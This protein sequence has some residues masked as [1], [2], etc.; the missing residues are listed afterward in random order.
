MGQPSARGGAG[1]PSAGGGWVSC[2]LEVG[3]GVNCQLE[4]DWSAVS[5]MWAGQPSAIYELDSASTLT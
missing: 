5:W 4:V 3:G 2:Q 1:Q